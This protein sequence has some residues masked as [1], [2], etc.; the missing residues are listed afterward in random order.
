MWSS[1]NNE[2]STSSR[3]LCFVLTRE[4][5]LFYVQVFQPVITLTPFFAF[6]LTFW[7]DGKLRCDGIFYSALVKLAQYPFYGSMVVICQKI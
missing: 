6:T 4:S 1:N 2:K 3:V 5:W 7:N